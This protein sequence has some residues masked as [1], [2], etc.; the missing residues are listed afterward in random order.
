MSGDDVRAAWNRLAEWWAGRQGVDDADAAH[1]DIIFPTTEE[2]LAIQPG[3]RVLDVAC[4][5]GNLARRL[6]RRGAEVVA[7][8]IA[9]RLLDIARRQTPTDAAVVYRHLDATDAEELRSL[10]EG[11]FDAAVSSM[12][13]HDMS[14]IDPLLRTLPYLL[15]AGGRFVFSV[16]H[17]CF[18][19]A[20]MQK[21]WER[22]YDAGFVDVAGVKITQYTNA[23]PTE[24]VIAPG[25]P[26][27]VPQFHRTLEELLGACLSAGL[28]LDALR[29][30]VD[31]PAVES[32]TPWDDV[33]TRIP[34]FLFTRWRV[35]PQ[36]DA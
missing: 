25:Q 3:E 21:F 11:S 22:H 14:V 23:T 33:G 12:A 13:L 29:E 35:P 5:T 9:D 32:S 28:L 1:R 17:P 10:G 7:F 4:G 19:N 18:N 36:R 20:G 31:S 27:G 2:L 16:T 6:A 15:K 26:H 8:D 34:L 24:G 30:P